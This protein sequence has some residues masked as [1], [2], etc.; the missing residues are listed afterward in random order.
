MATRVRQ[1]AAG[2]GLDVNIVSQPESAASPGGRGEAGSG[3]RGGGPGDLETQFRSDG[4]GRQH[5]AAVATVRAQVP[6][7]LFLL[8]HGAD[9]NVAMLDLRRCIGRRARGKTD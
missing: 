5:A 3:A 7:A 4:L 8:E 2:G 1:V 6:L 9:P